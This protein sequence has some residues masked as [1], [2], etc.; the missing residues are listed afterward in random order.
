MTRFVAAILAAGGFLAFAVVAPTGASAQTLGSFGVLAGSTVTNTGTTNIFG[1]VGLSPGPSVVGFPPG[2]VHVPYAIHQTDAVAAQAQADLTAAYTSLSLSPTTLDLTGQVL[3]SGGTQPSLGPGVYNFANSAQLIGNLNLTGGPNSVF[4]FKIGTTLT[5]ASGSSIALSGG[6]VGANVFFVVGSSATL[7]TTTTFVGE[8]LAN[9][10]ITLNTG[11]KIICGS[12]LARSGAVTLDTNTIISADTA[13]CMNPN[14]TALATTLTPAELAAAFS[15][16]SG[17]TATVV[18]PSGVQGMNSFL[19]L[20]LNSGFESVRSGP[21]VVTA[22]AEN[23]V[24]TSR[25]PPGPDTVKVL[26]YGPEDSRNR[27]GA[28]FAPFDRARFNPRRWDAWAAAFAG[29]DNTAGDLAAGTHDTTA[30]NFGFAAGIDD[31]VTPDTRIGIALSAGGTNFDLAQS[32]G[33]GSSDMYQAAVYGRKNFNAAYIS[34]ALAYGW[35]DES[36]DRTVSVG[37]L[38]HLSAD[39]SAHDIAGQI[40]AGY[41]LGWFTPYAAVRMQTFYT[42]AYSE[43]SNLGASIFALNYDAH[44]TTD[45]R[46][47]LGG[48]IE[49]TIGLSDGKT[50]DLRARAAWAHDFWSSTNMV[51]RFQS[52]PGAPF[53]VTGATPPSDSFLFSGG[54]ELGFRNGFSLA[55]WVDTAFAR[56][57]QSYAGN[58][59]VRYAW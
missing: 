39:F 48:R 52:M 5:T 25:L 29:Q 30:R 2:I 6:A 34:A 19:S 57:S 20:V 46:T 41:R 56:G 8:I 45:T 4:I 44:T 49:R 23:T 24:P 53:A 42:P 55:S 36:T 10:S 31:R 50:L 18:A 21:G 32:L 37:G 33:S 3:G 15:Q 9:A 26:D 14:I 22:P 13:A 59:R 58:V 51:A 27:V 47:E 17:E 43:R 35:Y 7:G 54:A 38:E 16:L 40:E 1:N 12:A 11:A 28:I